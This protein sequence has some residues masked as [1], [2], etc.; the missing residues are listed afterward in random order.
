MCR[1][2]LTDCFADADAAN[3]SLDPSL[4][5]EAVTRD[6]ERSDANARPGHLHHFPGLE[7]PRA[8]RPAR[9]EEFAMPRV[10]ARLEGER[11]FEG[12]VALLE[13]AAGA[14]L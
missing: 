13:A 14:R 3:R 5:I 1:S 2:S 9:Q 10:R 8:W 6:R 12:R 7:H 11:E 4:L